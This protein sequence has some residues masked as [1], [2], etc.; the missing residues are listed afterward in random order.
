MGDALQQ[1]LAD[2]N[3]QVLAG[4]PL[5]LNNG[6][7]LQVNPALK[8]STPPLSVAAALAQP[9]PV[10]AA[11]A[12]AAPQVLQPV[13]AAQ[14]VAATG[15]AGAA[16][17][18][19]AGTG[20]AAGTG[21]AGVAQGAAAVA[22]PQVLQPVVAAQPVAAT[23][24][25]GVAP[26]AVGTGAP[27]P[28]AAAQ[29]GAAI[30]AQ[31]V[32]AQPQGPCDL[33][34]KLLIKYDIV[35]LDSVSFIHKI[36]NI[37]RVFDIVTARTEGTLK[38]IENDYSKDRAKLALLTKTKIGVDTC[39]RNMQQIWGCARAQQTGFSWDIDVT[40]TMNTIMMGTPAAWTSISNSMDAL[41][42]RGKDTFI[43][44]FY[45]L[46]RLI[47]E[48]KIMFFCIHEFLNLNK[49]TVDSVGLPRR[50]PPGQQTTWQ[51]LR[52]QQATSISAAATAAA[53]TSINTYFQNMI[54]L[55]N[56]ASNENIL[57]PLNAEKI[58]KEKMQ[59]YIVFQKLI[60][61]FNSTIILSKYF[62]V[63]IL[64]YFTLK[65][66]KGVVMVPNSN[67]VETTFETLLIL[68]YALSYL[69][70]TYSASERNSDT[71]TGLYM[72][73]INVLYPPPTVPTQAPKISLNAYFKKAV[74][75]NM[76]I[77]KFTEE[78]Q[79]EIQKLRKEFTITEPPTRTY[80]QARQNRW[81]GGSKRRR[82]RKGR[83][84]KKR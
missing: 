75:L 25:A 76:G 51:W 81:F 48:A 35:S 40:G 46:D 82:V 16:G 21:L 77:S 38:F 63:A 28:G 34:A 45:T 8:L 58:F 15:L 57:V 79:G 56:G 49:I 7:R 44:I 74:E 19:T 78:I 53:N 6:N 32:A 72:D 59:N 3:T 61:I 33:P 26:G 69:V 42:N 65:P 60:P 13:V 4:T 62:V 10:A 30:A 84:S 70:T 68:E 37:K 31:P 29:P 54:Q 11:A 9:A 52:S 2:V 36:Y 55:L 43:R 64:A 41:P 67:Y 66:I 12:A 20:T 73:F 1:L 23:G 39:R 5:I 18:G 80:K 27:Q 47:S 71:C 22:A 24:L 83:P 17:T 14:P 50:N